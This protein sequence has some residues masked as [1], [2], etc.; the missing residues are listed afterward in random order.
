MAM[1]APIPMLS[2]KT[3]ECAAPSKAKPTSIHGSGA[4]G[5]EPGTTMDSYNK[6]A[7]SM[8]RTLT[9]SLHSEVACEAYRVSLLQSSELRR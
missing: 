8:S 7:P 4:P 3:I 2:S 6:V 1:T 5:V 9:V